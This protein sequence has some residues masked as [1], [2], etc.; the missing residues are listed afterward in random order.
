MMCKFR[1]S[2]QTCVSANRMLV[3]EGIYDAFVGCFTE[4]VGA[5]KVADGFTEGAQ[6][7]PLIDEPAVAKVESHVADALAQGPSSWSAR[8]PDRGQFYRPRCSRASRGRWR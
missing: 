1:N 8:R 3:Q 5:L 2:G 6:V 7:G 4:A